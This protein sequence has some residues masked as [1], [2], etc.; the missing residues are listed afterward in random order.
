[1]ESESF[2][3]FKVSTAQAQPSE[4]QQRTVGRFRLIQVCT[5]K[6]FKG[7]QTVDIINYN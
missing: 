7:N 6:H 3:R 4:E 5:L 1:M 2:G